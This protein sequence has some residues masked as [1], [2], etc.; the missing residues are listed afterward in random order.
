MF[1]VHHFAAFLCRNTNNKIR[2][3]KSTFCEHFINFR[4]KFNLIYC[5][6]NLI[7]SQ[8]LQAVGSH[9][10]EMTEPSWSA[11]ERPPRPPS[12]GTSMTT[13]SADQPSLG[14]NL[15][16]A[17]IRL[18]KLDESTLAARLVCCHGS[19]RESGRASITGSKQVEWVLSEGNEGLSAKATPKAPTHTVPAFSATNQ[20]VGI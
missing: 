1:T 8:F 4:F 16:G 9:T 5:F 17:R 6:I 18:Q 11:C 15:P 14:W 20:P 19:Q 2:R 13:A 7:W 3:A 10:F 12:A